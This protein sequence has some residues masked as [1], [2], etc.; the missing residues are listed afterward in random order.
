MT[1]V[2]RTS[3]WAYPAGKRPSEPL[4]EADVVTADC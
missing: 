2:P 3:A 1:I 4:D